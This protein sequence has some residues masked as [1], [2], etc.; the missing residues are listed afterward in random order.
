M[1]RLKLAQALAR[2]AGFAAQKAA[3]DDL[4]EAAKGD[5]DF[6]RAAAL[7][8]AAAA[9]APSTFDR[10]AAL[11]SA[12]QCYMMLDDRAAVRFLVERFDIEPFPDFS[13]K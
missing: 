6:R 9:V 12:S 5:E 7:F 11:E 8:E 10:A 4:A 13:A 1:R 3:A 2:M